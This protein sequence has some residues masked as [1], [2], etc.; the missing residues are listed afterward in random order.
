MTPGEAKTVAERILLDWERYDLQREWAQLRHESTRGVL[1][2]R[3]RA[4]MELAFEQA[5]DGVPAHLIH[6]PVKETGW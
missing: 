6:E 2:G 4:R 5:G 1:L 3:L